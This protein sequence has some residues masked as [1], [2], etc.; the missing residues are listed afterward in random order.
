[1]AHGLYRRHDMTVPLIVQKFGGT[2]VGGADRLYSVA[3]IVYQNAQGHRVVVVVSAMS[4]Y[5]KAEGTTSK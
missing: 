5:K 2:S 3:D 4:G 1:M